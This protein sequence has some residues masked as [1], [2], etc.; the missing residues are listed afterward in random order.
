M[1]VSVGTMQLDTFCGNYAGDNVCSIYA[2]FEVLLFVT[3]MLADL[4]VAIK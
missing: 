2:G 4:S 3:D 1:E